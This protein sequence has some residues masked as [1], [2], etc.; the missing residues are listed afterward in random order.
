ML[1]QKICELTK[2]GFRIVFTDRFYGL[3][4]CLEIWLISSTAEKETYTKHLIRK[5]ELN[6]T[7]HHDSLILAAINRLEEQFEEMVLG[8]HQNQ[9]L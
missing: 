5:E 7:Y 6:N 8:N 9:N 3:D 2:R 1:T 4:P